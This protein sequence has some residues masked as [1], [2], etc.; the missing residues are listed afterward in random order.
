MFEIRKGMW[1]K[2]NRK[3]GIVN[4][5]NPTGSNKIALTAM[6]GKEIP[7]MT[8]DFHFVDENGETV[9]EQFVPL[10]ELKEAFQEDIPKKR[11]SREGKKILESKYN[12]R[13]K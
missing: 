9:E 3:L 13:G 11:V 8:A 12:K 4:D 7:P 1:A 2:H 10:I 6:G 5:L